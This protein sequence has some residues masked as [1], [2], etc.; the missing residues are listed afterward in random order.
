MQRGRLSL[1][2]DAFCITEMNARLPETSLG[3]TTSERD[4]LDPQPDRKTRNPAAFTKVT[5]SRGHRIR[6]L[7]QRNSRFYAQMAVPGK[8]RS[9]KIPLVDASGTPFRT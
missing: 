2:P 4:S 5:D 9:T 7:W 1:S 3:S 8:P 6:R